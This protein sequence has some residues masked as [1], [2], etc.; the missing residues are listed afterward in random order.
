M[1]TLGVVPGDL[2][3][4]GGVVE[5]GQ[6]VGDVG[7]LAEDLEAVGEADRDPELAVALVVEDVAL[8]LAVG[9]R[10]AAQ[11]DGDVVDRPARAAD[12]LALARLGLE[13][14]AAEGAALGRARVVLLDEVL[15]DPE[16]APAVGPEALDQEAA[17]VAV[18]GRLDRDQPVDPGL[19]RI[20]HRAQ[21]R[22][23]LALVVLA[24]F[25]GADRL[26]PVAVVAIP[27]DGPLDALVE[28]DLRP[29]AERLGAVGGERVAAV[30]PE[31]VVD[32]V[33]QRLVATGELE[34]RRTTSM[35]GSSSGP[36]TL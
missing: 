33:D 24:V 10:A 27:G 13:V 16:L 29:P 3:L 21:A 8:P 17:L 2:R 35:F 11:V 4:G 20:R 22:P 15:V 23:V 25:A 7:D 36:P 30:V 1:P 6:L 31:P 9:G 32:V 28:V 18:D 5:G 19:D 26:P 14:H 34:D 12:E